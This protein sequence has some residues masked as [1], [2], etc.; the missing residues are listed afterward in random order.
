[1]RRPISVAILT[2]AFGAVGVA[3]AGVISLYNNESD[4]IAAGAE[5][6][7]GLLPN[8]AGGPGITTLTLGGATLT[9]GNSIFVGQGWSTLLPFGNAIAI[10]G[11]ENLN[12][13]VDTGLSTGFGFY[14]HEPHDPNDR[15]GDVLDGCNAICVDSVFRID[16]LLGASVVTTVTYYPPNNVADFIGLILDT[17]FDSVQFTELNN[18]IDNEFFGEMF[19]VRVPE[20][21]TLSLLIGGLALLGAGRRKRLASR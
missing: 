4:Y 3:N 14:F 5:S 9:A 20:P 6:L 13:T 11:P 8:S 16:F 21:G 17:P 18:T 2:L 12:V 7:T 19:V 1:M 15:P 10:S